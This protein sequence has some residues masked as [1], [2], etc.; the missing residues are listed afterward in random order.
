MSNRRIITKQIHVAGAVA[1]VDTYFDKLIK[2]IPADIVVAWIAATGLIASTKD[3]SETLLWI[4][5]GCG[6]I[7][8]A[9]WTWKQTSLPNK[10][11]A[12]T[13]IIISTFAFI[14]WVFATGGP[15]ATLDFYRPL[16]GSLILILYTLIIA[17]VNP[18]E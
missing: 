3:P 18:P 13:Q 2:Y 17:L 12:A 9:L 5:F 10:P 14:I 15:F 7:L 8:T 6:I 4:V 11:I 16:Y 1:E